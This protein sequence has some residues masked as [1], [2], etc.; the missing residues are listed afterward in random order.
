MISYDIAPD[1]V[2]RLAMIFLD[3]TAVVRE[4]GKPPRVRISADE[5][6]ELG[7]LARISGR[8]LV[9]AAQF[10]VSHYREQAMVEDSPGFQGS[11]EA[12][13]AAAAREA[14][15]G[16]ERCANELSMLEEHSQQMARVRRLT[17]HERRVLDEL[18]HKLFKD[19]IGR[20]MSEESARAEADAHRDAWGD[21]LRRP[22]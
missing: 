18:A 5:L 16:W 10:L 13:A 20:G 12:E 2:R 22:Q 1:I 19:L 21:L 3:E 15:C 8:H 9:E 14:S 11:I 7:K 6:F 4:R 17:F